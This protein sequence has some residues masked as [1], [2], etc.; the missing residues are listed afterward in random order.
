MFAAGPQMSKIDSD[1]LLSFIHQSTSSLDCDFKVLVAALPASRRNDVILESESQGLGGV[2]G[3]L[4]VCKVGGDLHND[5]KVQQREPSKTN[6]TGQP[7]Y[8]AWL[9]SNSK[10]VHAHILRALCRGIG[11]IGVRATTVL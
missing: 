2:K 8:P 9:Q 4:K 11:C 3:C 10:Y 7:V 1:T 6:D 5:Q